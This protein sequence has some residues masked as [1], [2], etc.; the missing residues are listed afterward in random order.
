M[1]VQKVYQQLVGTAN[2]F[3]LF[4]TVNLTAA[5]IIG[6]FATPV[7]LV[8]APGANKA[9]VIDKILLRSRRTATAFTGGGAL[10]IHYHVT[11]TTVIATPAATLITGA[12]GTQDILFGPDTS[13][14]NGITLP[15]NEGLDLT[16]LLAAFAAGTGTLSAYIWYH[17]L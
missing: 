7:S 13:D 2:D 10:S 12:A 1:G 14:P 9:L 3:P 15:E 8:A 6:M 16:N 11:T 4:R 5:Q 17:R